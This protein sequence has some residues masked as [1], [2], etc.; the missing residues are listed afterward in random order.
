VFSVVRQP[1]WIGLALVAIVIAALCLLAARWQWH[2]RE[3]RL[4]HNAIVTSHLHA[5]PVVPPRVLA[6]GQ[7]LTPTAEYT[8]VTMAGTWDV[9]HQVLVR[10]HLGRAGYDVITPLVPDA[11]P[12]LLVDRGW[13]APSAAGAETA[14]TIPPPTSGGSDTVT[15]VARLRLSE[16]PRSAAG[17][18]SG[19]VYA[20]DVPT[21][22]DG[23]PY[24]VFDA[25][26]ELVNQN[27]A[28]PSGLTLPDAPDLGTGPHLIYAIQWT[29]F[30][31]IALIGY[32]VLVRREV[33]ERRARVSDDQPVPT[34]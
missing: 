3:S 22:A 8:L 17:L 14:P 19:Q 5:D 18:P 16:T 34:R 10:N 6:A 12:A 33:I 23:L 13:I 26:G 11:G 1:R 27:P 29:C 9:Q 21:I 32:V 24:P 7:P 15:V 4:A 28:P 30:A 25:Y 31:L 20:I 2:R